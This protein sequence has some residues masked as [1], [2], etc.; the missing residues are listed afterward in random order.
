VHYRPLGRTGLS[1]SEIGFGAWGIGGDAGGAIAYGPADREA[2]LQALRSALD[3]GITFFDTS[4]FYGNGTSEELI[5]IALRGRR[6]DAVIATKVGMLEN[7]EL[8]F[9]ARHVRAAAAASLTRLRADYIDLYQL[10]SPPIEAVSDE[11]LAALESLKREGSIR[12]YGLSARSPQEARLAIE[13]FGFECVQVNFNLLDQRALECG[14]FDLAGKEN[15]GVIVRTPLCFGFLTG[16]YSAHDAFHEKDHRRGWDSAQLERWAEACGLYSALIESVRGQ[17]PAQF[18]LRHCLAHPAVSTAIPGMLTAA[19][20]EENAAA[21]AMG[22]P[23]AA[24][25]ARVT[26]IYARNEFFV[27]PRSGPG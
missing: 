12:A 10:H 25:R 9:S 22:A 14:L 26:D 1:V 11:T 7:G 8:D 4:D 16:R 15:V 19:H 2:S 27:R 21:S 20:V 3:H 23:D 6:A 18:A 24:E 13:R 5:G 17:T